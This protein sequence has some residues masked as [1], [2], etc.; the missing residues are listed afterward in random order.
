MYDSAPSWNVP[1]LL[2]FCMPLVILLGKTYVGVSR[3]HNLLFLINETYFPVKLFALFV[4]LCYI[5]TDKLTRIYIYYP[6]FSDISPILILMS[7]EVNENG[8][9]NQC[10]NF[11]EEFQ[12]P[13]AEPSLTIIYEEPQPFYFLFV[14]TPC[15]P[16]PHHTH[17]STAHSSIGPPCL[18]LLRVSESL[19]IGD[20][21]QG[22]FLMLLI[23]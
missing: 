2:N 11:L 20:C 3:L 19:K 10:L 21:F 7:T 5:W 14:D 4:P 23:A 22:F 6:G 18:G 9:F 12:P 8:T 13:S 17:C 1:V 16:L 15:T